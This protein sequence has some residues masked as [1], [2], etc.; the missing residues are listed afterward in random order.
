MKSVMFSTSRSALVFAC[1]AVLS[2]AGGPVNAAPASDKNM[3]RDASVWRDSGA[4]EAGTIPAA[5]PG[6]PKIPVGAEGPIRSDSMGK[7]GSDPSI[8]DHNPLTVN[9]LWETHPGN[10]VSRPGR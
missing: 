1:A 3:G 4:T 10:L 5:R 9:G 8:R 6:L 2:V 7:A